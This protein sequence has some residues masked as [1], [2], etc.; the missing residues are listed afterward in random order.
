MQIQIKIDPKGFQRMADFTL[1]EEGF[2]WVDIDVMGTDITI[3]QAEI[4]NDL[5]TIGLTLAMDDRGK[6]TIVES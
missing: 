2:D 6:L 1:D 4:L 5:M 3:N